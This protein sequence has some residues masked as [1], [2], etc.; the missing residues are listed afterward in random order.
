MPLRIEGI[1][2]YDSCNYAMDPVLMGLIPFFTYALLITNILTGVDK[3]VV[4]QVAT[5]SISDHRY[6]SLMDS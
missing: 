3:V 1:C 2:V 6:N 4:P 5:G